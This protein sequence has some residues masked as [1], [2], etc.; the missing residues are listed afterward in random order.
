MAQVIEEEQRKPL[1]VSKDF[2][3]AYGMEARQNEERLEAEVDR[4]IDVLRKLKAKVA[5][6]EDLR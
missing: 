2:V 3:T 5:E 4:H 6:R 1:Q